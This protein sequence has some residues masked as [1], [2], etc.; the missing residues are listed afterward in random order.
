MSPTKRPR[1][2]SAQDHHA[3]GAEALRLTGPDFGAHHTKRYDESLEIYR[4]RTNVE[5][6]VL[7]REAA[8]HQIAESLPKQEDIVPK[9]DLFLPEALKDAIF[10]GHLVTDLDSVAGAIGAAAL[11]GG[12]AATA[13]EVN[14]ETEFALKQ[15]GVEVPPRIEEMLK[16]N[17]NAKVSCDVLNWNLTYSSCF[18]HPTP[19]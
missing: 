3:G 17:P 16:Q 19:I 12:K 4:H 6:I 13:S 11:Y 5:T 8:A 9:V 18:K 14:S 15:W 10:V 2:D 7:D 1:T